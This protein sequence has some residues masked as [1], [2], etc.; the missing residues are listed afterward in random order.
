MTI[1]YCLSTGNNA[2]D[3]LT[4][5]TAKSRAI[6]QTTTGAIAVASDGDTIYI[7]EGTITSSTNRSLSAAICDGKNLTIMPDPQNTQPVVFDVSS[8]AYAFMTANEAATGTIEFRDITIGIGSSSRNYPIYL[9]GGK[10]LTF[11]RCTFLAGP[12]NAVYAISGTGTADRVLTFTDCT[13]TMPAGSRSFIS[14]IDGDLIVTRGSGSMTGTNYSPFSVGGALGI[15]TIDG[16][17]SA[18]AFRVL[19]NTTSTAMSSGQLTIKNS[20]FAKLIAPVMNFAAG[21][22]VSL[23]KIHDNVFAGDTAVADRTCAFFG[24]GPTNSAEYYIVGNTATDFANGITAISLANR[25]VADNDITITV[26]IGDVGGHILQFGVDTWVPDPEEAVYNTL[27][28]RLI[29]RNNRVV[30]TGNGNRHA[31]LIPPASTAATIERN[32][33][34]NNV[35]YAAFGLVCKGVGASIRGNVI[36]CYQSA[37]YLVGAVGCTVADNVFITRSAGF[38]LGFSAQGRDPYSNAVFNN[39]LYGAAA[40]IEAIAFQTLNSTYGNWIDYNLCWPSRLQFNSEEYTSV[41]A[42]EAAQANYKH[43]SGESMH[44]NTT[45]ADPVVNLTTYMSGHSAAR[46]GGV[47]TATGKLD[48]MGA[49]RKMK[50]IYRL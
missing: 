29:V 8:D 30:V 16:F 9:L 19:G 25:Y 10:S 20:N 22:E 21:D 46:I 11:T 28:K 14:M 15:V 48:G 23:I 45:W 4:R 12:Q 1:Y 18:N 39:I 27:R 26:D 44:Q 7:G 31:M 3:G 34:S 47:P 38:V 24:T 43:F 37:M 41:A 50:R 6:T 35:S 42:L 5:A 13:F 33:I 49:V 32:Y 17:T 36:D 2:N 40:S